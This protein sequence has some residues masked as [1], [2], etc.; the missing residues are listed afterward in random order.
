M[1]TC[2]T[3]TCSWHGT[4]EHE[5]GVLPG[6]FPLL[7]EQAGAAR[8]QLCTGARRG[9]RSMGW[10]GNEDKAQVANCLTLSHR[11]IRPGI[12]QQ[13]TVRVVMLSEHWETGCQRASSLAL[14]LGWE[15]PWPKPGPAQPGAVQG[16]QERNHTSGSSAAPH[17]ETLPGHF[18]YAGREESFRK[19]AQQPQSIKGRNN[20]PED[21]HC[22][23]K[24]P[25]EDPRI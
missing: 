15:R 2:Y 23:P 9:Q 24:G 7:A 13:C 18:W 5:H 22:Q 16:W 17:S 12:A 25:R 6:S 11:S 3:V 21:L 1:D 20:S 8:G 4:S 19:Q 14:H 10:P